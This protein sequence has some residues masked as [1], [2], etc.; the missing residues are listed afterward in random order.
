LEENLLHHLWMEDLLVADAL[1]ARQSSGMQFA[2]VSMVD[3]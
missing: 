3:L 1:L 2:K